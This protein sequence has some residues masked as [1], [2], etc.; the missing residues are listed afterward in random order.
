MLL[1]FSK[2]KKNVNILLNFGKRKD[3]QQNDVS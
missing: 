2:K 1:I 3:I